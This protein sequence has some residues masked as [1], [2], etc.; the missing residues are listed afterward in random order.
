MKHPFPSLL[1]QSLNDHLRITGNISDL[2]R[3]ED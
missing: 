1:G 3:I 2:Q